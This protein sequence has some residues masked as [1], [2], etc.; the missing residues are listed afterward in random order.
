MKAFM[1]ENGTC[2]SYYAVYYRDWSFDRFVEACGVKAQPIK[3]VYAPSSYT[4]AQKF[5]YYLKHDF[6]AYLADIY[7]RYDFNPRLDG[8]EHVFERFCNEWDFSDY[9]KD[10]FNQRP[11]LPSEFY[12]YA[13]GYTDVRVH[14]WDKRI[15]P[16]FEEAVWSA[17]AYRDYM[18]ENRL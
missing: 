9:Y 14:V 16:D 13:L 2:N 11:H 1:N 4:D 18:L 15:Q 5:V 17:G 10:V 6:A 8:L 7:A 3:G 12:L